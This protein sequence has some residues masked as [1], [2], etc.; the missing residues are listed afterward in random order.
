MKD[1]HGSQGRPRGPPTCDPLGTLP[2]R[3]DRSSLKV[4][5]LQAHPALPGQVDGRA[6]R[7]CKGP[8]RDRGTGCSH[9]HRAA[10]AAHKCGQSVRSDGADPART[11]GPAAPSFAEPRGRADAA[12]RSASPGGPHAAGTAAPAPPRTLGSSIHKDRGTLLHGVPAPARPRRRRSGRGTLWSRGRRGGHP[13]RGA[14]LLRRARA[15]ACAKAGEGLLSPGAAP[16]SAGLFRAAPTGRAPRGPVL[17]GVRSSAPSGGRGRPGRGVDT[18][19]SP[20]AAG[21]GAARGRRGAGRSRAGV[22]HHPASIWHRAARGRGGGRRPRGK[23]KSPPA[24]PRGGR[25]DSDGDA[26]RAALV[27][28]RSGA[29]RAPGAISHDDGGSPRERVGDGKG[30]R[31]PGNEHK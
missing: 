25:G 18:P 20:P 13:P 30:A 5:G 8:W 29:A 31:V 19:A 10:R 11:P 28:P 1:P 23:R 15:R 12:G 21:E 6:R 4:G 27:T 16:N 24:G 9:T 17:C 22:N 7:P 3:P 2:L 14:A 26:G